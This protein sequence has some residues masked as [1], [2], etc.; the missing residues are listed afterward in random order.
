M[1]SPL[2]VKRFKRGVGLRHAL[3]TLLSLLITAG[4]IWM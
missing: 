3:E 2:R 1:R 4:G